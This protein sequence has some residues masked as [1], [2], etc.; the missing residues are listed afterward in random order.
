MT[1]NSLCTRFLF[2]ITIFLCI[3]AYFSDLSTADNLDSL[4][5]ELEPRNA[6]YL[7]KRDNT[8]DITFYDVGLGAC[9]SCGSK[10]VTV[11]VVDRCAGCKKNDVDLSP[12]AF[13]RL[14]SPS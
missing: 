11:T 12:A 2:L 4:P 14:L 5:N 6:S 10:S 1:S 9:V 8:G 7:E 13:N 3:I